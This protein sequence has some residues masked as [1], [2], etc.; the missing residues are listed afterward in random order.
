MADGTSSSPATDLLQTI[1]TLTA[2]VAALEIQLARQEQK[3]DDNGRLI[4][5]PALDRRHIAVRRFPSYT[6]RNIWG[7]AALPGN[8][9]GIP[10]T[11][12]RVVT[13]HLVLPSESNS[14][15]MSTGG[16][17]LSWVDICAGLAAKML[18][19]SPCVTASVDSVHFLRPC[20]WFGGGN[21]V[22]HITQTTPWVC[23]SASPPHTHSQ[24][25]QCGAGCCHGQS[26]FHI[27]HGSGCPCG[28]RGYRHRAAPSLL[29]RLPH[30]CQPQSPANQGHP[31]SGGTRHATPQD[32]A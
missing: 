23:T 32:G 27:L 17:V 12:T 14:L 15:G 4:N 22:V 26:C 16:Q 11:A 10:M 8:V 24:A 21:C 20:R 9:E 25:R 6:A 13:N 1:E 7:D 31:A 5:A 29:Q 19:R 18:A 2:R 3:D 28:G 30:L